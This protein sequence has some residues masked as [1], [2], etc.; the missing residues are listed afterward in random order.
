[1]EDA[2]LFPTVENNVHDK[3]VSQITAGINRKKP[4]MVKLFRSNQRKRKRKE[5]KK[6]QAHS[7]K[8]PKQKLSSASPEK[9]TYDLAELNWNLREDSPPAKRKETPQVT[10]TISKAK[11]L[12]GEPLEIEQVQEKPKKK[13]KA[14]KS[15]EISFEDSI[16]SQFQSLPSRSNIFPQ[17]DIEERRKEKRKEMQEESGD[18]LEEIS[19]KNLKKKRSANQEGYLFPSHNKSSSHHNNSRIRF[20]KLS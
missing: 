9:K 6:T 20:F 3:A 19:K 15:P 2:S 4:K 11:V 7:D 17:K 13:I 14:A 8:P 18:P 10:P 1:M 16:P 5:K 12:Y